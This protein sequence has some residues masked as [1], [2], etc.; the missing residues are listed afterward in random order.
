MK[1]ITVGKVPY[2]ICIDMNGTL[3]VT[4]YYSNTISKI[5]NDVAVNNG[6]I[7]GK[8]PYGIGIDRDNEVFV[9]NYLDGT[10]SKVVDDVETIKISVTNNPCGFG[11]FT[12][13]QA[14]YLFIYGTGGTGQTKAIG[15]D[16]LDPALQRK[17]DSLT[18]TT[19]PISDSLISHDGDANYTTVQE[20]LDHLLNP[21]PVIE[22]LTLNQYE[23]E[24]G[25]VVN[26]L[27]LNWTLNKEVATQTITGYGTVD[28]AL[29]TKTLNGIGLT[30]DSKFVLTVTDAKGKTATA[31][32]SIKFLLSNYIGALANDAPSNAE[33]LTL[34][35][36]LSKDANITNQ[37]V[38][39]S[40]GK[41]LY[42]A[43]P[44]TYGLDRSRIMVGDRIFTDWTTSTITL[45]NSNGY[46]SSYTLF[47]SNRIQTGSDIKIDTIV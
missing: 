28:A 33:L 19:F 9:T 2:G 35:S 12:G 36:I 29:R 46:A 34:K 15:Y 23:Y 38:N 10:I 37:Y 24:K 44:T 6:I 20:A 25:F 43:V 18:P 8:G 13:M 3:W 16:D 32:A 4:N 41:Y 11:D 17:L 7:V 31:N 5:V 22:S 1:D 45:T 47:K 40:G 21:D 42:I 39:A 14:Y 27:T 30:A 26:S